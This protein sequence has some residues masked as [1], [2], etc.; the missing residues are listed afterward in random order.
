MAH[1]RIAY[2]LSKK[3]FLD[4]TGWEIKAYEEAWQK[5]Q[6]RK[7]ARAALICSVLANINRDPKKTSAYKIEDFMPKRP[8]SVAEL[9][10]RAKKLGQMAALIGQ[11]KKKE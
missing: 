2:G 6:D 8:P 9:T 7:H 5:E 4:A 11:I 1:A 10:R 3:E